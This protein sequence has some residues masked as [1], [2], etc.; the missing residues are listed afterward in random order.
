MF[1][2]LLLVSMLTHT[3]DQVQVEEEIQ[4]PAETSSTEKG[5]ATPT[6]NQGNSLQLI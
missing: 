4:R 3:A 1:R 6:C 2:S 5:D